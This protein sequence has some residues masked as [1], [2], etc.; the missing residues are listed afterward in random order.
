MAEWSPQAVERGELSEAK[1]HLAPD[2]NPAV[3]GQYGTG[4]RKSPSP[5]GRYPQLSDRV[6][7]S[8]RV[9]FS[10]FSRA[11]A[12]GCVGTAHLHRPTLTARGSRFPGLRTEF[13]PGQR[14]VQPPAH[15]QG[16]VDHLQA[17]ENI[18]DQA[19]VDERQHEKKAG[20]DVVAT[21]EIDPVQCAVHEFNFP[22]TA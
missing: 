1:L 18:R 6:M 22:Y 11:A 20:F 5:C 10:F 8:F 15:G 3:P 12:R 16:S 2:Q 4:L 19:N 9:R 13:F 17:V 21:V 14:S 7:I